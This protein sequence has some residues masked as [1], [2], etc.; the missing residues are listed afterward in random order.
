MEFIKK[1][2]WALIFVIA[3]FIFLFFGF[4]N[5]Q[6]PL[7]K[8]ASA[9][10]II[11]GIVAMLSTL[12]LLSKSLRMVVLVGLM[13]I[14]LGLTWLDYKAIKDPLDFQKER[15]YRYSFVIENLKDIREAQSSYKNVYGKYCG[16]IDTLLYFV[17]YDSMP[18]IK[19]TGNVPDTLTLSQALEQG[20]VKMDTSFAPAFNT[21]FNEKYL[22]ER[23]GEFKLDSLAYV[24]FTSSKFS[25]EAGFIERGKVKVPVFLCMDS[26]PFDR[27]KVLQVGSMEDPT[28]SGNWGE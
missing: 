1:T 2:Y 11:S 4:S 28:T 23:K 14:S 17:Q 6:T 9:I 22:S 16:D 7:F 27:S 10:F 20:I 25:L 26:E 3:G 19:S 12:D 5:D 21:I 18:V 13:I 15:D 8:L 24:P